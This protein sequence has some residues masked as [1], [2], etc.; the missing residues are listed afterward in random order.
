MALAIVCGGT[1]PYMKETSNR[2]VSIVLI[3]SVLSVAFVVLR[4]P[5]VP[6]QDGPMHLYYVD[7]ARESFTAHSPYAGY[8]AL[9]SV[10]PPYL[11]HYAFLAALDQWLDPVWAEKTLLILYIFAAV[12]GLV[13]LAGA[14]GARAPAL[15]GLS[16]I[17]FVLNWTV[18]MGF[19]NF[20][21]GCAMC[22]FLI[23]VWLR[24]HTAF[25]P[26]RRIVFALLFF[27]MASMH[28]VPVALFMLFVFVHALCLNA[29]LIRRGSFGPVAAAVV[30]MLI[31]P[32]LLCVPIALWVAAIDFGTPTPPPVSNGPGVIGRM[33]E[34]VLMWIEAP[35]NT[36][37]YRYEMLGF[38]ALLAVLGWMA[39]R[40]RR[41]SPALSSILATAIVCWFLYLVVPGG[42]AGNSFFPVRFLVFSLLLLVVVA[43]VCASESRRFLFAAA[44]LSLAAGITLIVQFDRGLT[45]PAREIAGDIRALPP[46]KEQ[47][48][49]VLVSFGN[50]DYCGHCTEKPLMLAGVQYFRL[51]RAILM[52]GIWVRF[53]MTVVDTRVKHPWDGTPALEMGQ[54]LLSDSAQAPPFDF[55]IVEGSRSDPEVRAGV[56]ALERKYGLREVPSDASYLEMLV[57]PADYSRLFAN[58][59]G[60]AHSNAT[61]TGMVSPSGLI[62]SPMVA[63]GGGA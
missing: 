54:Y 11:F 34:G 36:H 45:P 46:V 28:P 59:P 52:N 51:R 14:V 5:V 9:R 37:L 35:L 6:S 2:I 39:F 58:P 47:A 21:L 32:S 33:M 41:M 18:I 26:R 48:R 25:T 27:L 10:L 50:T 13:F 30:R 49:G 62:F 4:W 23:G 12:T 7:I 20:N 44:V 57:R 53:P 60:S 31:F 63:F 1:R 24:F 61:S 3:L 19:I 55:L 17:P 42:I 16:G 38:L 56:G 43:S 29:P 8:Y 40:G 15:A 22:L